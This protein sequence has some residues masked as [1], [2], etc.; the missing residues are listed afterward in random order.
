MSDK[1]LLEGG[2]WMGRFRM[3]RERY[4]NKNGYKSIG[5]TEE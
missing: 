3:E 4:Y 2:I 5:K 1:E